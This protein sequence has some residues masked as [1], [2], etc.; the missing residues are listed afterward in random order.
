MNP[1]LAP[2][3]F[4]LYAKGGTVFT[5]LG[6]P[7]L[8]SPLFSMANDLAIRLNRDQGVEI[9]PCQVCDIARAGMARGTGQ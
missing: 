4:P 1:V 7:I 8:T 3:D 5:R 6:L 9:Q 2:S